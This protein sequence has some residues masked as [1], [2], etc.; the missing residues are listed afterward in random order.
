MCAKAGKLP[1]DMEPLI[2]MSGSM[3]LHFQTLSTAVVLHVAVVK[4]E[5]GVDFDVLQI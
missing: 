4:E 2:E 5:V 1:S 3:F